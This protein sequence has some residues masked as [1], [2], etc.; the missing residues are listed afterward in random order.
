[1]DIS[2]ITAITTALKGALDITKGIASLHNHAEL[3]A[4]SIELNSKLIEAQQAIFAV[5]DERQRLIDKVRELE[6]QIAQSSEWESEKT[7]YQLMSPWPGQPVSV[8][9]LKKSHANGDEPHWLCPNC[10]Q[11]KSKSVLNT[12]QKKGERVH[13]VCSVCNA[14]INTG[15]N[16]IGAPQYA[17][18]IGENEG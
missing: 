14:S 2:S 7:R 3:S 11:Q 5:N 16:G 12:N 10:F 4:L 6:D 13:F 17:E 1:M 15:W 18:D 9:H 8:Y